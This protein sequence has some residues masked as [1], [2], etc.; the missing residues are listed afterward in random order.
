MILENVLDTNKVN[1]VVYIDNDRSKW[2]MIK[3]G[4]SIVS[5]EK[6]KE[7]NYDYIIIASQFNDEIYNQLINMSIDKYKIF[8]FHNFMDNYSNYYRDNI[9]NFLNKKNTEID[10]LVTGISYA[11]A[12]FREDICCKNFFNLSFGSQDLFYDYHTVKY[13]IDNFPQKMEEIKYVI[14]GLC[15]YSFQY[16]MSLSAMKNKTVLY[17]SVLKTGHHFK[18]IE[19]VYECHELNTQIANKIFRKK[20]DGNY[21][22]NWSVP[23]LKDYENKWEIGKKQS[24]IDCNKDYPKTV[25]ENTEIFEKY[26]ELLKKHHIKPI[27]VV[28][29]A[30][31]YYTNYF[32]R[33]IENEFKSIINKIREKH[34]FQFLDYF[35]S[36]LFVDE[37]FADVS[38]LNYYGAEKFTKMLN[39]SIEW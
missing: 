39:E 36:D 11:R 20:E 10:G 9:T 2:N 16:D 17:Y 13:L 26:L 23:V 31:K 15:Y 7:Y 35:R 12:G 3:N 38:H 22:F 14:I 33:K 5:A 8:Q 30:S 34:D 1:I 24:E 27:I 37:E 6:I 19:R 18:D 4:R 28:F 29:T 32:S 25:A 21:D